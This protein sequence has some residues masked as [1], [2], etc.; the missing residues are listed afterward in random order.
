MRPARRRAGRARGPDY[1]AF[2]RFLRS[3][4]VSPA[5]DPEYADTASLAGVFFAERTAGLRAG[6]RS[7]GT[8]RYR[9]RPG[10]TIALE[11]IPVYGLCPHHLA[12]YFGTVTV[13]YAPDGRVTGAGS[14]ARLVR[15][16][17][18]VPRLQ[19]DLAEAVADEIDR[20]LTPR[21]IE[22]RVEARHLC[23]EM[24]GT[25]QRAQFVTEARRGDVPGRRAPSKA[26]RQ[27]RTKSRRTRTPRVT[28]RARSGAS[29]TTRRAR[30]RA[31]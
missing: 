13:R 5:R 21:W 16:L 23:L 27:A 20:G 17:A 1:A 15:D 30:T 19:E 26:G 12:P 14:L 25:Q 11:S 29:G 6:L 31:R 10:A 9:G 8:L 3:L 22:V 18:L 2:A 7:L 28:S 24:R 4:G